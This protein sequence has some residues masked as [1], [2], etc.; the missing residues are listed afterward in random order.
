MKTV[1]IVYHVVNG[2]VFVNAVKRNFKECVLWYDYIFREDSDF[3]FNPLKDHYCFK[4]KFDSEYIIKCHYVI[5]ESK[6]LGIT[7]ND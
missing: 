1:W 4:S 7:L 3:K 5:D 6:L 2:C